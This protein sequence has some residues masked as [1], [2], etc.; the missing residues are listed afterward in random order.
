[1]TLHPNAKTTP[2][3]RELLTKRVAELGWSMEDAA[4]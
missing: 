3:A 2:F 1:V 4:H